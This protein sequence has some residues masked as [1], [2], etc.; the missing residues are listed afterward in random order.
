MSKLHTETVP[1]KHNTRH[2]ANVRQVVGR[3][4]VREGGKSTRQTLLNFPSPKSF[5]YYWLLFFYFNIVHL[6][7]T[8]N[9]KEHLGLACAHTFTGILVNVL[10]P[11]LSL[12]RHYT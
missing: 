11:V 8:N 1:A 10:L 7:W 12:M 6:L 2:K 3:Q 5:N 9:N 4:I